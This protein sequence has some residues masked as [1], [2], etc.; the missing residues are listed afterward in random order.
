MTQERLRF[1]IKGANAVARKTLAR[2][3][4]LACVSLVASALV[5]MA[6]DTNASTAKPATIVHNSWSTGSPMPV[7]VQ[8]AVA[9]TINGKIYVVG[10]VTATTT[11]TNNQV[12]DPIANTWSTAAP[13]PAPTFLAAAAVYNKKLYVFGGNTGGNV[14]TNLVWVYN[15]STDMWKSLAPM[16]SFR[17]SE[18]AVV[19]NKMIYVIGGINGSGCTSDRCTLVQ[20]YSP[21][22][23]TWSEP[24]PLLVGVSELSA[25]LIGSTIVAAGG[26]TDCCADTGEVESYNPLTNSW[27]SAAPEPTPTNESCTGVV[28]GH[29]FLL[30]GS[31]GSSAISTS[32]VFN[33]TANQWKTRASMPNPS[34]DP[35]GAVYK[36]QI[37][38]FGGGDN[39]NPPPFF[40]GT[41]YDYV[42]IYQP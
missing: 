16:P 22:T 35:A 41:V 8:M 24:A 21:A 36:G 42:Q 11:V 30:G 39:N 23:N 40:G 14:R 13:I 29:L 12:Y 28:G 19:Y 17:A 15:P 26:Y 20:S 37:Y 5:M 27:S 3:I 10:G 2:A 18:A 32:Q 4:I 34:A 6:Q 25:G 38:C 1:A 31:N 7:A 33:L 9:G